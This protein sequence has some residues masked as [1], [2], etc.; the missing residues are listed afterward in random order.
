[1]CPRRNSIGYSRKRTTRR[2]DLE[3]TEAAVS[4][5]ALASELVRRGLASNA[6]LSGVIGS[7][8]PKG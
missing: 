1:M 5:D 3:Q 6:I 8:R 7:N 2:P 4:W